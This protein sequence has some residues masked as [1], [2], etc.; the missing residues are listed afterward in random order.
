MKILL[1][2]PTFFGYRESLANEFIRIGHDA[3]VVDD[4]P[5]NSALFKS[6]AKIDYR[7][8]DVQINAYSRRLL[9]CLLEGSFDRVIY[10]GG[11]SFCFTRS[12]FLEMKRATSARFIAYLWD[13]LDNCKRFGACLDVFDDVYS[14]EPLDCKRYGLKFRPLFYT[15]SYRQVPFCDSA[16]IQYDACF[17]GSVHQPSKF[18]AVLRIC[19]ELR[20]LGLNVFTYFYMPSKSACWLRKLQHNF[21]RGME[22]HYQ[23]LSQGE[24]AEIYANSAAIIDAPQSRQNGLTIRSLEALGCKRK[25]ITTN[26]DV[27]HYDFY[28]KYDDV[29]IVRNGERIDPD[30]FRRPYMPLAE[31]IYQSYSIT[32]FVKALVEEQPSFAGYRDN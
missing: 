25:L 31:E 26:E 32:S 12:Q 20:S 2:A 4:R 6:L 8:L 11:M 18:A 29:L 15:Q 19:Q 21:Y 22:F 7:L 24:V 28:E 23:K 3:K 16:D 13:A 9:D 14:F 1:I 10:L 5:S 27:A 30:F 17:I